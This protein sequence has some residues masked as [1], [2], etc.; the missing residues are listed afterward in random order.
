MVWHLRA[1]L[2]ELASRLANARRLVP[3]P[4][5]GCPNQA[6]SR[7]FVARTGLWRQRRPE[8]LAT[9]SAFAR[10][11]DFVWQWYAW[12]RQQ[13]ARC[14]PNRAHD[15]LA[16]WSRRFD[17][18]LLITQNVDGLHERARTRDVLRF[19]GSIWE[20]QCWQAWPGLA[21]PLAGRDGAVSGDAAALSE[22]SRACAPWRRLVWRVDRSV[23]PP[24]ESRRDELRHLPHRRHF[25]HRASRRG[26][27]SPRRPTEEPIRWK[28]TLN[29]LRPSE[30]VNLTIQARLK[31]C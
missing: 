16:T 30:H 4:G 3:S 23:G 29:R 19:H 2:R 10:D 6:E 12:R 18:F 1:P 17:Q 15:V 14:L 11:P 27:W 9:P 5:L 28:S 22:L 24:T 7:P 26:Q 25:S 21:G 20:L 13:V 8:Q 31:F